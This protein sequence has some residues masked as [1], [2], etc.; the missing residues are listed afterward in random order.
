M[1]KPKPVSHDPSSPVPLEPSVAAGRVFTHFLQ[2]LQNNF[3][4]NSLGKNTSWDECVAAFDVEAYAADAAATGAKYAFITIMQDSQFMIAPNAVFDKLTGYKPGEACATRDLVLDLWAALNK[5]GLKLGLYYTGDGACPDPKSAKGLA[6]DN[7]LRPGRNVEFVKR[8]TSVLREFAVRYGDKV[9]GWWVD[10]C[11]F[12]AGDCESGP[13][14]D[15]GPC[16]EL[17]PRHCLVGLLLTDGYNDTTLKFYHDA[18]RA[19]NPNAV[20]GL[21]NGVH[22]PINSGAAWE[23][24]G[25]VTKWEDMTAGETNSFD[26]FLASDGVPKSRW[27]T[28]PTASGLPKPFQPS[29]EL[30]TVQFHELSFMGSQW[31]A[32]GLCTCSG[33]LAPNCSVAGC[34]PYNWV[35]LKQYLLRGIFMSTYPHSF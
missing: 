3:G 21:N 20:I 32:G 4:R 23:R 15:L 22:A 1:T 26:D 8:W 24:G 12:G 25:E 18:I 7:G 16:L 6:C 13:A 28:A 27:V 10:G 5:R 33:A 30:V 14:R 29:Q 2:G 9:F 35:Q 11:Y 19:G 31:A 34:R 17:T